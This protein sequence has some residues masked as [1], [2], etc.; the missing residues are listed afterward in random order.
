M[1]LA[2]YK[3]MAKILR[4]PGGKALK[5]IRE[6]APL[7]IDRNGHFERHGSCAAM[8]IIRFFQDPRMSLESLKFMH[9]RISM[10]LLER[11]KMERQR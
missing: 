4:F 1:W 10:T 6:S 5:A 11:L 8:D 7:P 2:K 3:P 9:K